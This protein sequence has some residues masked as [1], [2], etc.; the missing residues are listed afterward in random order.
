MVNTVR[1]YAYSGIGA[2]GSNLTAKNKTG[3]GLGKSFGSPSCF[4]LRDF[5]GPQIASF[6][7]VFHPTSFS[8]VGLK[9]MDSCWSY[10]DVGS[11]W[12]LIIWC[13]DRKTGKTGS[14]A[15]WDAIFLIKKGTR[16]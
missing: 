14:L 10:S 6:F 13:W 3:C 11:A 12:K 7:S 9:T 1:G 4:Y 15:W 2:K 5:A 8:T 16:G